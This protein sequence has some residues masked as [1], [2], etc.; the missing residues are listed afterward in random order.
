M[1]LLL[2]PG[3]WLLNRLR[4][5]RKF[6]LIALILMAPLLTVGYLLQN[7]MADRAAFIAQEREGLGYLNGLR[8]PLEL[9]QQHRGLAA[10]LLAG[11]KRFAPRLTAK[12]QAVDT[13]MEQLV[14]ARQVAVGGRDVAQAVQ[15]LQAQWQALKTDMPSLD[16]AG[17]FQRH[18]ALI[19]DLLALIDQ[20]AEDTNLDLD[21]S[22]ES[23]YLVDLVVHRF[24]ELAEAMGQA[25][26]LGAAMAA[27]GARD[28]ATAIRLAVKQD[29]LD[30]HL[31][32]LEHDASRAQALRPEL[33]VQLG[34]VLEQAKTRVRAFGD[35]LETRLLG[36][37]GISASADEIFATS[38]Q[39]IDA[40]FK[41]YDQLVP[42]LDTVLA[43]Q[44]GHFSRI[45]W[46]AVSAMG[47]ALLVIVY[48]FIAF[49]LSVMDSIDQIEQASGRLAAG[50]LTA[51]F[52]LH[53]R[54]ELNDVAGA[55]NGMA[56]G[57]ERV[58]KQVIQSTQQVA[59]AAEE[60]SVVTEQTAGGVARQ[61]ADTDQVASAMSEMS[62]TVR[63]V[64]GTT[65]QAAEA[66][67]GARE[68][69]SA[70]HAVLQQSIEAVTDL[71]Q[72][73]E[74]AA[75]V[76]EALARQSD[77]IG[78]V[79]DVINAIA[80]Q[81]NLLALNA[82]IEAAR[83]GESGRGFAV[84]ADEVRS[85]AGRTRH[86]TEEIQGMIE[87]LQQGSGRAVEVIEG[88]RRHTAQT[89]E[90]AHR[91]GE[92]LE[93]VLQRVATISDMST[94]IA[95]ATEQQSSVAE[96]MSRNINSIAD[97][98]EQT[99]TASEQTA[100]ASQDMSRLSQELMQMVSHF[101]VA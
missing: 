94:Q 80:E 67:T 12:T 88:G 42:A 83:A 23:Y 54:D 24:P 86:S 73:M 101:V 29:R 17:S 33:A 31:K 32:A 56:E 59:S 78:G 41:A 61:R 26:G 74:E 38:T 35:M 71:S 3:I 52:R 79:L 20:V 15:R 55:L 50:D 40:V 45:R 91:T 43:D 65:S 89:V 25:R 16:S 9:L 7:D 75:S 11:D 90:K 48:F 98:S 2:L 99:A 60:L 57:F 93:A 46:L 18:T 51:R 82:A 13:A 84:V 39:A 30:E 97:V 4:Y 81:T 21:A 6:L 76:I 36:S 69:A 64:A 68:E 58:V 87:R 100:Q 5:P 28:Q 49:Y 63:E 85:L 77:E 14:K 62:A 10:G 96:E 27:R 95:S 44:Q 1:R 92:A 22:L 19:S 72:A 70:G 34:P 53:S 66:A 8:K 47:L 37:S